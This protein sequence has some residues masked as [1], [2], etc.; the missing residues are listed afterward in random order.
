MAKARRI[1][2]GLVGKPG[3]GKTT[4]ARYLARQYDFH[5]YE[6]GDGL[7]EYAQRKGALLFGPEDYHNFHKQ[8]QQELGDDALAQL[9]LARPEQRLAFVGLRALANAQAIQAAGGLIVALDCPIEQRFARVDHSGLKYH[10]SFAD[11]QKAEEDVVHSPDGYCTE[12]EQIMQVADLT[13]DTSQPIE[14]TRRH[15]DA[16]IV[17]LAE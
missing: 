9:F 6:S 10:E 1:I 5:H 15:I 7:R 2:L 16:L 11:F 17:R 4:T 12:I 8:L 13:I 3:S 14:T